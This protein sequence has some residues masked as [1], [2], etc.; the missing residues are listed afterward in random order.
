MRLF[1]DDSG[2]VQ[3]TR[4]ASEVTFW[5]GIWFKEAEYNLLEDDEDTMNTLWNRR[6]GRA[7]IKQ[8]DDEEAEWR[9]KFVA[10]VLT[11]RA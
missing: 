9:Y 7:L 8:L 2:L 6:H 11:Q 10:R 1:R 5:K 4:D 3:A